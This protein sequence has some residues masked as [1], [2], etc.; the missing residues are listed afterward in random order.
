[1][2]RSL[3]TL[4]V[5]AALLVTLGATTIGCSANSSDDDDASNDE[6]RTSTCGGDFCVDL[7]KLNTLFGNEGRAPRMANIRD[8]FT[9]SVDL[10]EGQEP[11]KAETHVFPKPGADITLIPYAD[12]DGFSNAAGHK[13]RGDEAAAK[14]YKPGEIGFAIKHHRPKHR[15][16]K[17][18]NSNDD[19]M[20][21]NF[22]LQ[23]THIEVVV[24]VHKGDHD[25]VVTVNNPQAYQDGGFGDEESAGDYPMVFTKPVFPSYLSADVQKAMVENIRTM[26]VGFNTVTE[27]PGD[28]NGGDPLGARDPKRLR[29]HTR[30]MIKAVAGDAAAR[31]Y[32]RR[33]ENFVYCAE[34]AF[35]S[36]SAGLHI[37]L[38]D[39]GIALL[40]SEAG[41]NKITQEEWA[42]FKSEVALHNKQDASHKSYFAR[43]N[44]NRFI[45]LVPVADLDSDAIKKLKPAYEYAGGQRDAESQKLALEPMTMADIVANFMRTHFPREQRGEAIAPA[46]AKTLVALKPGLLES[47]G[48]GDA[49]RP[50]DGPQRA[51]WDGKRAKVDELY[52]KIVAAVGK[53]YGSYQEFRAAMDP[54]MGAARQMTGPRSGDTG[55]GL[56]TPP[57]LFHTVL[58]GEHTNGLMKLQYLGH[59]LHVK[60]IKPAGRQGDE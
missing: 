38:N 47:M 35:L 43:N 48:F 36:S 37:P 25:G 31:G 27:F 50:A 51:E 8:A 4:P 18:S 21:E 32:F 49:Q 39:A 20:K 58:Q 55:V 11:F 1:M 42:K 19:K 41:D 33:A 10:G 2:S 3:R 5:L 46:M 17:L 30:M 28:Y 29:E 22:K 60:V 23:D 45:G 6:L 9:V 34:L 16:L 54:L 15:V 56:F 52:T 53:Q 14:L 12:T 44:E 7:D 26:L 40:N 59:G 57:S 24:G 13:M